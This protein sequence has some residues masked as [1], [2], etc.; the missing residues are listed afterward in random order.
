MPTVA[1][2]RRSLTTFGWTFAPRRSVACVCRSFIQFPT[3]S[4]PWSLFWPVVAWA[5]WRR[6]RRARRSGA[7]AGLA[8]P[9]RVGR[10]DVHLLLDLRREARTLHGARHAGGSTPHR[11]RTARAP[12]A[13]LRCAAL[14]DRWRGRRRDRRGERR[15]RAR[16]PPTRR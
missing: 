2:P 1:W 15:R 10:R 5:A 11:R 12:R 4:M 13:M 7:G 8:I 14:V 6:L 3:R 16:H 9:P